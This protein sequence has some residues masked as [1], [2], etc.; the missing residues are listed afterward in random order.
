MVEGVGIAGA[1]AEDAGDVGGCVPIIITRL[2]PMFIKITVYLIQ[3]QSLTDIWPIIMV[4]NLRFVEGF[5]GWILDGVSVLVGCAKG[6]LMFL[7]SI[8][9][10][11]TIAITSLA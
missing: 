2:A 7:I 4:W 9:E 3:K 1:V 10:I 6:A 5:V 11:A 8:V